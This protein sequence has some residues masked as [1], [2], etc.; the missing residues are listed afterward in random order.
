[1][2]DRR[3]IIRTIEELDI[4]DPAA[5]TV[6]G[7]VKRLLARPARKNLLSGTWLGHPLHPLLTDIPIGAW[8]AASAIDLTMG[9]SGRRAARRLVALGVIAAVPTAA[10]GAAD[11]S[12]SY[13]SDQR[14]GAVHGILNLA[15]TLLQLLSWRARRRG[16]TTR[17]IGLSLVGFTAT[18]AAGYLGGTLS[19]GRGVGVNHTAFEER[20]TAW[21]DAA[22]DADLAEGVP[23]RVEVGGV[24]VMLVRDHGTVRALSATCVHAG[25]PLDEGAIADGCVTCPWHGSR[26]RLVD[27]HAVQGPAAVDQP[28]WDVRV[29]GGRVAVRAA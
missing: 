26:F 15:G 23:L 9:R 3:E 21:T 20:D 29:D 1:M 12:D 27:G 11:W 2:V 25:G 17:G 4:V 22:A 10:A 18:A 19:F 7:W 13:G 5:E 28:A 8:A 14:V 16:H 24:P 6:A